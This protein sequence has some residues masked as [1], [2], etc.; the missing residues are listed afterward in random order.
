MP[1]MFPA[2]L[3]SF[4]LAAPVFSLPPRFDAIASQ[5]EAAR[6][7][8]HVRDAIRLY[9]EGTQLRPSWADG[10]WYLGSLL[11]DQDR[12]SEAGAAFQH[13]LL[14]PPTAVRHLPFS[15]SANTRPAT[16]TKPWRNFAH[17]PVRVGPVRRDFAMLQSFISHSC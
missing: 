1:S 6:T 4:S 11:Y 12:F 17:G 9:R 15:A 10:W 3:L 13:L 7:Q 5:A 8:D 2:L 14:I 16:T